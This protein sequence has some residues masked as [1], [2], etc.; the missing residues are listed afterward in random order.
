[1]LIIRTVIL[2]ILSVTLLAG[3]T[4]PLTKTERESIKSIAVVNTFP[5]YP[6]YP[7]YSSYPNSLGIDTRLLNNANDEIKNDQYSVKMLN[8]TMGYLSKKGYEV[9][10][11]LNDDK[12]KDNGSALVLTLIPKDVYRMPG[13]NGYGINQPS[14]L[15]VALNPVAYMALSI[16]MEFRGRTVGDNYYNEAI[17]PLSFTT[18]PEK[19]D[20]L[21]EVQKKEVHDK[22]N[23]NI[24]QALT[25]LLGE[26]DI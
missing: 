17:T 9:K 21:S 20:L 6:N 7:G 22:L 5:Q 4:T 19:W 23:K 18:L 15:G 16:R 13:T 1:M 25:G 14:R 26:L 10:E 2:F 3:C 24:E 11:I 12:N 8:V